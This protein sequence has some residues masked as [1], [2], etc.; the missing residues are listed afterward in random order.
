[1]AALARARLAEWLIN[2]PEA[3]PR[4]KDRQLEA[5]ALEDLR[6]LGYIQ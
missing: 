6:A 5:E 2:T 1:V 4:A 3:S